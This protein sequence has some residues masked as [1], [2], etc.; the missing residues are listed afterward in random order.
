MQKNL[1]ALL[2]YINKTHR[3]LLVYANTV[4]LIHSSRTRSRTSKSNL[5]NKRLQLLNQIT[6][7]Q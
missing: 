3:E 6:V 1:Y 2:K 4:L 5:C 7:W